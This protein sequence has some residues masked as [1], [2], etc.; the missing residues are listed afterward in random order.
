MH[1]D[2]DDDH[3]E[4]ACA[5]V[6]PPDDEQHGERGGEQRPEE[7]DHYGEPGEDAEGEGVGHVQHGQADRGERREKVI[8]RSSPTM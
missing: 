2:A 8:A 4:C 3:P 7:G 6:R 5:T 1:D